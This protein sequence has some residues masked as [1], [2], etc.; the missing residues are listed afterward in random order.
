MKNLPL[1]SLTAGLIILILLCIVIDNL[2]PQQN[3]FEAT[4]GKH[5]G[6]M[7]S[8]LAIALWEERERMLSPKFSPA[9]HI[10]SGETQVTI[11]C[12]FT[13]AQIHY[14][15]DGSTPTRTSTRY[16]GPITLIQKDDTSC[17]PLKAMAIIDGKTGPVVLHT[18][19]FTDTISRKHPTYIFSISTDADNLYSYERG[20]LVT[21]KRKVETEGLPLQHGKKDGDRKMYA[22]YKEQG[23]EW[24][25]PVDVEVFA[26]DG[27]RLLAQQSGLR[28]SGGVSRDLPQKSLRLVARSRYG[29][30]RFVWPFFPANIC[31]DRFPNP[32]KF[33]NLILS[34]TGQDFFSARIRT[35]LL[36]RLAIKAGY[37]WASPSMPAAVYLN[38]NY[39][40]FA[41][42]MPRF[43]A[44]F[45]GS[46]FAKPANDFTLFDGNPTVLRSSP[47]YPYL[48]HWRELG[49]IN[50]VLARATNAPVD[51]SLF[52]SLNR[53]LDVRDCLTYHAL[54]VYIDNRD[55]PKF[56]LR[57]W[58]YSG[59]EDEGIPELDGRWRYVLF[60]LDA[61]AMGLFHGIMPPSN[62]TL[63]RILKDSP[64]LKTL[65]HHKEY[66][67]QFA[68]DICDMAFVHYSAERVADTL[69]AMD[70]QS[71]D[72][73]QYAALHGV[74]P[75]PF[76][77]EQMAQG[78]A[79][80]LRFFRERPQYMLDELRSL[81][82][83]TKLYHVQVEGMATLNTLGPVNPNGWYFVENAVDIVPCLPPDR[84]F[85]RW[86]VN[87]QPREDQKLTVTAADAVDNLVKVRLLSEYRPYPLVIENACERGS[88]CG[89]ALRNRSAAAV[90]L[91]GL[92]LSDNPAK[93]RQYALPSS[94]LPP[95]EKLNFAG[96]DARHTAA[97]G[98]I[99]L[100]FNPRRGE[101]V[102]LYNTNGQV[103]TE[104]P[105]KDCAVN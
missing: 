85:L 88:I 30:K 11:S 1:F 21:G 24:E 38:G 58:R 13:D 72:E 18:Y 47:K 8:A 27:T 34:N 95:G 87:G 32:Q 16:T 92:F 19:F 54:Q 41:W 103:L 98:K 61:A 12:S 69:A 9:G 26:K 84:M 4:S 5:V 50:D 100:N 51:P 64:L 40:G 99:Q 44:N 81:L 94:T 86:E 22:N 83:F 76:R 6:N 43:D 29:N 17:V 7:R 20:L 73:P 65:L 3:H 104:S 57:M 2:T 60:D 79:N 36:L 80:I 45:L 42:L 82:R 67:S 105:V 91:K 48:L 77:L 28:I 31:S 102:I 25:R 33:K 23:S 37:R 55:W 101:T 53:T 70:E 35:Q 66:V 46:L 74:Y 96:K 78:R 49:E 89:F 71:G 15:T 97:L 56:N 59:T 63:R 68:N 14:T 10:L 90:Q 52:D 62:K 93:P 75:P 39:Y